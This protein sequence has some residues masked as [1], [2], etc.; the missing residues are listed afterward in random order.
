MTVLSWS[1]P[2]ARGAHG[3]R[4]RFSPDA[5]LAAAAE[6]VSF[7]GEWFEGKGARVAAALDSGRTATLIYHGRYR[8]LEVAAGVGD[9]DTGSLFEDSPFLERSGR[10]DD[11]CRAHGWRTPEFSEALGLLAPREWSTWENSIP[12]ARQV[13]PIESVAGFPPSGLGMTLDVSIADGSE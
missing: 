8:G 7:G 2:W 11:F 4:L 12:S 5:A 9:A 6:F 1:P 3:L 13:G 10:M